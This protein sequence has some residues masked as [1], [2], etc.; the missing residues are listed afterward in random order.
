[1]LGVRSMEG[2]GRQRLNI[3]SSSWA[4]WQGAKLMAQEE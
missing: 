3:L 2:L 4:R 1:M